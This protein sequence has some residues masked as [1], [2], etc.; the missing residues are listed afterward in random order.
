MLDV[1]V[2]RAGFLP[3]LL[4][5]VVAAFSLGD[6]PRG[7][8]T[9]LP[10]DAF[11]GERAFSTLAELAGAFPRRAAG[12]PGDAAVADRVR[13]VLRESGFRVSTRRFH[14]ATPEGDRD[15]EDV[16]GVHAGQATGQIVVVAHRDA[17][18][19]RAAAQLSG[20]AALMELAHVFAGRSSRKTIVLVSTSGGSGGSAG[21]AEY[22]RHAQTAAG[23]AAGPIDAAIALGDLAGSTVRRPL[24][25]PWSNGVQ[26]A[27]TELRRTVGDAVA[28]ETDQRPGE[29]GSAAQLARLAFPLTFGEQ[30]EL[31]REGLPAVL[32]S[33]SGERGPDAATPVNAERLGQFGRG[34]LR[35]VSALDGREDPAPA[36]R[37]EL[38]VSGKLLPEWAVSLLV[39]ALI[40]PALVAAV[41]AFARVRRQRRALGPWLLW[42]GAAALGPAL[43]V[44]LAFLLEFAGALPDAPR[45]PVSPDALPPGAGGV[46]ALTAIVAAAAAVWVFARRA[47]R[48]LAGAEDPAAPGAAVALGLVTSLVVVAVWAFNPFAAALLLPALHFWLLIALPEVRM[49]RGAAVV[50]LA[51]TLLPVAMVTIYYAVRLGLG[52]LELPWTVLLLVVGG[53]VSPLGALAWC[54]LIACLGSVVAIVRAQGA[55]PVPAPPP[56]PTTRGPLSYAGPGSLGG[57]ESALPN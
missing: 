7:L 22:A 8:T 15:L 30:G 3:A 31:G 24:V 6:P 52:P 51:V 14:G 53:H 19:T 29:V 27:P 20:T 28:L 47:A 39:G 55:I 36:A 2:Y 34:V 41:D 32:L 33:V 37:A 4:A 1:R 42:I 11:N 16:I 50:V 5:L 44:L 21:A 10:P 9:T 40:V 43:A 38:V 35:S 57:T 45:A 54:L 49:R 26:V 17:L 56:P 46:A 48:R 13:G 23:G 25:V 12:S 18:G